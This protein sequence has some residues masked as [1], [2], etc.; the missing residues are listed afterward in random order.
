MEELLCVR[1]EMCTFF[2]SLPTLRSGAKHDSMLVCICLYP[3]I[4]ALLVVTRY[5]NYLSLDE[6]EQDPFVK[7]C[8][9]LFLPS[10]TRDVKE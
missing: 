3:F 8:F 6:P 2:F 5:F 10:R 4:E 1:H 9:C 7:G